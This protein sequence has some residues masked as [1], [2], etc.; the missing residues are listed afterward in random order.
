M[1]Q[2][3]HT[4]GVLSLGKGA[5]DAVLTLGSHRLG[6][7][8][9]HAV[10]GNHQHPAVKIQLLVGV[11]QNTALHHDGVV[12]FAQIHRNYH[13]VHPYISVCGAKVPATLS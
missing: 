4:L 11:G 12:V 9:R 1:A 13:S 2:G 10:I 7:F 8:C 6:I 3:I 5:D